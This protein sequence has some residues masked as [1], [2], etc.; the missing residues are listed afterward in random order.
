MFCSK[1]GTELDEGSAFC[2]QCGH[3]I[4]A[5]VVVEME[6]PNV[7]SE[8]E[9]K[10]NNNSGRLLKS[11]VM[12][13]LICVAGYVIG[14]AS[15]KSPE[16]TQQVYSDET[17]V[18]SNIADAIETYDEVP[19]DTYVETYTEIPENTYT[20]VYNDTYEDD[21]EHDYDLLSALYK[22]CVVATY[23]PEIS[24]APPCNSTVTREYLEDSDWGWEVLDIMGAYSL[25]EIEKKL[26]SDE[27][28]GTIIIYRDSSGDYNVGSGTVIVY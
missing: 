28:D 10:S 23:D 15:W 13:A 26:R 3:K 2:S 25:S 24:D 14:T 21:R 4:V 11:V 6:E 7:S 8:K 27:A 17:V 16:K 18:D 19:I 12:I 5:D 9:I 22:A 20:E 1:C